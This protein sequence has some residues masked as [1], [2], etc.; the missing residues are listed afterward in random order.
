MVKARTLLVL[1]AVTAAVVVGALVSSSTRK[2]DK[3]EQ[4]TDAVIPALAEHIND[5]AEIIIEAANGRKIDLK[6]TGD[7]WVD[8]SRGGYPAKFE[9][10]KAL[11]VS[12]A[13]ATI[14]EHKTSD[15]ETYGRLGV[16]SLEDPQSKSVL[17]TFRDASDNT[18]AS[19]IIG[20]HREGSDGRFVRL[21][22]ESEVVFTAQDMNA[23][24][25]PLTWL[26]REVI[27][28]PRDDVQRV[29]LAHPNGD[30]FA[31]V[32]T[33][34]GKFEMLGVP[35]GRRVRGQS[36]MAGVMGALA[37]VDFQ[38]VKPITGVDFSELRTPL[39][40]TYETKDG[41]EIDVSVWAIDREKWT[42]FS[43]SKLESAGA[44][45]TSPSPSADK[46]EA[47]SEGAPATE[48]LDEKIAR[49]QKHLSGWMYSVSPSSLVP[50]ETPM[51][52][53]TQE[54]PPEQPSG[55]PAPPAGAQPQ[56][57]ADSDAG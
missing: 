5:V 24:A 31:I 42:T 14:A 21:D 19:I 8:A 7:G 56:P 27:R 20:K 1:I 26:D 53:L 38:D 13:D 43:V 51:V 11:L 49:L 45:D 3:P 57:N 36:P 47:D 10:V 41:M 48:T 50:I 37:Y 55:P 4:A 29:S 35:E 52:E 23:S 34:D 22:D 40:A 12:F 30:S 32:R 46:T 6:R 44:A 54:I 33:D 25:M 17:V 2:F 39:L 28:I 9:S 16:K 18:I 15:P